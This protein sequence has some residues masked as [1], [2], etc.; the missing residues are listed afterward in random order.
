MLI[1]PYYGELITE[2]ICQVRYGDR[3]DYPYVV[4]LPGGLFEDGALQRGVGCLANHAATGRATAEL[5]VHE[6]RIWLRAVKNLYD[7]MEVL[8]NYT[9][10]RGSNR[11]NFSVQLHDTIEVD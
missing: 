9:P 7:E 3:D 10:N 1:C 11:F 2:A 4:Q 5:C 6:G 8:I